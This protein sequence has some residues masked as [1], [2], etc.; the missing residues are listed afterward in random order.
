MKSTLIHGDCL[1]EMRAIPNG[2]V[3]LILTDPP[4]GTTGCKWD[5]VIPLNLMWEQLKRVIKPSGAIVINAAEPF[6][7]AL[8]MSNIRDYKYDWIWKKQCATGHLNAKKRPLICH[9]FL[10]VFYSKQ[11]LYNPQFTKCETRK[12]SKIRAGGADH[13]DQVYGKFRLKQPA[14]HD[15]GRRYPI[16]VIS[17][18]SD[19]SRFSK[20]KYRHPTKK[21]V[22]LAEY[23]IKTYTNENE[24]VLDFAAGSF[25]T[26]VACA[27][28]NRKFIGI[29]LDKNYFD[30]G[31]NRIKERIKCLDLK[32]ELAINTKGLDGLE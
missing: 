20:Q 9:E 16:S 17:V 28:L 6:A 18:N 12:K 1:Q 25:T 2:S 11:C 3:D 19:K 10:C 32:T 15:T 31:V 4:F 8:R 26:G 29:E 27:N 23:M 13:E 14:W 22:K 7:S 24:T 30:I 21:P 5:S